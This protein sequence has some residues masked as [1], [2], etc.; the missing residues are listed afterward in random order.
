[1][2]LNVE[3]IHD[4]LRF[5]E[6]E[7]ATYTDDDA[8]GSSESARWSRHVRR[9]T[10]ILKPEGWKRLNPMNQPTLVHPNNK[11]CLVVT[12]GTAGT[13]ILN[14]KPTNRNPKGTSIRQAVKD[15][16]SIGG[17]HDVNVLIS[18]ETLNA[19]LAGL[20][21]TWL[22]MTY[23]D[24]HGS[25]LS[26]VSLPEEMANEHVTVWTHRIIIPIVDPFDRGSGRNREEPPGYDF[27]VARR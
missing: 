3:S 19:S 12:S 21:E 20:R 23:V 11:H 15:N 24:V 1:M 17:Y 25:L 18:A 14:G 8:P 6:A 13:G 4:A 16:R 10:E 26:E 5:G 2:G 9:M 27:P 7:S 22:L